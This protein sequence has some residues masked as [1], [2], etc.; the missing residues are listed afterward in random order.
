M[1]LENR[2]INTKNLKKSAGAE[3]TYIEFDII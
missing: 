3:A 1:D 2:K